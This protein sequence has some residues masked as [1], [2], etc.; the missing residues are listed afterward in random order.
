MP[1]CRQHIDGNRFASGCKPYPAL[2]QRRLFQPATQLCTLGRIDL[3]QW[4]YLQQ[5]YIH[6]HRRRQSQTDTAIDKKLQ[7][8][9]ERLKAENHHTI[10]IAPKEKSYL[11]VFAR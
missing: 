11:D 7:I 9:Q 4:G 2:L 5:L 10:C 6:L 8:S 3:S 1:C